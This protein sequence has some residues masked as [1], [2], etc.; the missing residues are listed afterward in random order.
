MLEAVAAGTTTVVDHAHVIMSPDHA[1]LGISAT[2]TSGVRAVYCYGLMARPKSLMPLQMH[3]NPLEDWIMPTFNKLADQ[4]PF[5]DGRVT[6]GFAYDM[7]F[8]PQEVTRTI[9]DQVNEKNVRTITCH[10]NPWLS[11]TKAV[12]SA[13]I[14]DERFLISHGGLFGKD[15]VELI[16][17]AKAHV[18][19]TPSTELQMSL[20][21]RPLCFDASFAEGDDRQGV[22]EQASLGVDCHSNQS[23]SI[24]SEARIGLQDARMHFHENLASCG[25][26]ANKLPDSL[27]VEAVFNLATI[28][29]A[30]AINMDADVGRIAEGYKADLVVFDALSPAMICAAQQDPVASIILHSSPADIELVMV[31][32]VVRK[33]HGA[34]LP[35]AVDTSAQG[36]VRTES[37]TWNEIAKEAMKS[38][39]RILPVLEQVDIDQGVATLKKSWHIDESVPGL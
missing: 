28:K 25:T 30:E 33:R 27:S 11:I 2:A 26:M 13:G 5:G 22:Q 36:V 23:G 6:L 10:A 38:R 19:S 8:L 14:L 32:G 16:K 3:E 20:G 7:W 24:I 39:G 15:D 9:F 21:G 1:R 18:S 12:S 35:V 34:L 17:N 4:A 37:L 29:G 31:D